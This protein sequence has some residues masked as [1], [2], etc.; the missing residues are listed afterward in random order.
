MILRIHFI[1]HLIIVW[2]FTKS[3]TDVFIMLHS[4][5]NALD[6]V[7]EYYNERKDTSLHLEKTS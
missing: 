6:V 7:E 1:L 3:E 5:F 4:L 2:G